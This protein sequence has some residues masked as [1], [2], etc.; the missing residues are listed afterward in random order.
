[1]GLFYDLLND[2]KHQATNT[3]RNEARHA[4]RNA[5]QNAVDAG[6]SK[7]KSKGQ[8]KCVCGTVNSGKFCV[9][10]GGRPGEGTQCVNCGWQAKTMI[11]KFCP[12]CGADFDGIE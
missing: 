8:W 5:I 1:M 4:T 12:E 11:P 10:C 3:L 9:D 2:V 6:V 7:M